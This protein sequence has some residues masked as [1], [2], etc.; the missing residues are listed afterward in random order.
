MNEVGAEK[1]AAM[2]S[3]SDGPFAEWVAEIAD[4][5]KEGET[6]DLAAETA[7]RPNWAERIRRLIPVMEAMASNGPRLEPAA[8]SRENWSLTGDAEAGS[9]GDFRPVRE[10]GRGGMGVVYEALQV[11]LNRRVALKVLPPF[12][13]D[14]PHRLRRFQIE[15]QAAACLNHPHLVPVYA[16]GSEGSIPYFAM[17]LI[18]GRTLARVTDEARATRLS[19]RAVAEL[20]T[21]A[22]EALQYAHAQGV[23]HRDVKPSNLLV[24]RSGWLWVADFGL[25]MVPGSAATTATG[26]LLGTLRYMSP[27]QALGHRSVLDHRVDVYSLGATLY[28]LLTLRPAF[29]GDDRIEVLRKI[30]HEEPRAPRRIDSTIPRDLETVVLK[31]MAKPPAE[32]YATAADLADDLSRFLEDRPIRARRASLTQRAA[33]WSRQHTR[34]AAA[35]AV[36][37]LAAVVGI[38]VA[39]FWRNSVL[40]KHNRD[41]ARALA[42]A[43]Q[44]EELNRRLWY[45]SQLRLAQQALAS[46]QVELAQEML[47]GLRPEPGE[48]AFRDFAWRYLQ[49]ICRREVSLLRRHD[50]PVQLLALS[51]DGRTLVSGDYEGTLVFCDLATGAERGRLRAHRQAIIGLTYFSDGRALASW[52]S[53]GSAPGDVALWDA[54]ALKLLARVH[55]TIGEVDVALSPDSR[56]LVIRDGPGGDG[57]TAR[58]ASFTF[59]GAR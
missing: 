46:G 8:T 52:S 24:D 15:A 36:L 28:E 21:Q 32:R 16:V 19:C 55:G 29:D 39:L 50:A 10:F 30:A 13:A 7:R 5:M 14:D 2:E 47:E 12:Q 37:L 35:A 45:G 6:L 25:A 17:Q 54:A 58:A 51:P 40:R 31:A 43:E 33:R 49:R 42:R 34:A 11:S 38:G 27:E 57:S 41:L 23:I 18:E 56:T 1:D 9:L 4:R 53:P 48:V 3:V 20:D 22:A 26:V 44:N 59:E